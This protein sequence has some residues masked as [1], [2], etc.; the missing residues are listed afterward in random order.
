MNV[1]RSLLALI[2]CATLQTLAQDSKP[3]PLTMNSV[4]PEG[5]PEEYGVYRQTDRSW[6]RIHQNRANKTEIKRGGFTQ[7][8]GI[9]VGG[10]HQKLDYRGSNAQCQIANS[11]LAFYVRVADA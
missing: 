11:K 4:L 9:G 7:W 3:A 5:L 2:V 1:F 6:E 10:Y 8:T